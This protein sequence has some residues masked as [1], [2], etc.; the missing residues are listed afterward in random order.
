MAAH[1]RAAA[2]AGDEVSR[3]QLRLIQGDG[4]EPHAPSLRVDQAAGPPVLD[5]GAA[6]ILARIV[7]RAVAATRQDGGPTR[8]DE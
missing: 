6:Q 8:G 4:T 3:P 5:G 2:R 1:R 7:Q